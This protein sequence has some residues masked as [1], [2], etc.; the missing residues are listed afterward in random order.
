MDNIRDLLETFQKDF[1]EI[2]NKYEALGKEIHL[3]AGPLPEKTRW[4]LKVAISASTQHRR[5]LETHIRKA[6]AAGASDEEILQTLLLILPTTGFPTFM[7]AYQ[8]FK[9]RF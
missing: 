1:P 6:R 8:I 4:L 3:E 9:E 7:E 2:Y 5:A